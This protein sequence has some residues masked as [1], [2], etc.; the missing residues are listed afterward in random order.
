MSN[1]AEGITIRQSR[2]L[3]IRRENFLLGTINDQPA[4]FDFKRSKPKMKRDLLPL[5]FVIKLLQPVEFPH[6]LGILGRLYGR[7]LAAQG[8]CWVRTAAGIPWKLDLQNSC[9]RWIVYGKYEGPGFINWA[10]SFLPPN[11]IVVDSG[12]NIGQMLLYLGQ[13]IPAGKVLAFEPGKEQ[14]DWLAECLGQNPELPVE[15]IRMGL[16]D[17]KAELFLQDSGAAMMHGGQSMVS[18]DEGLPITVNRLEDE[19]K[20]RS[21]KHVD[22]WKLDVEGHEIKALEGARELLQNRKIRAL[23]V[24]LHAEN[25]AMICDFL[26]KLDYEPFLITNRGS[27]QQL[28]KLPEHTN[29]LFLPKQG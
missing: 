2:R 26:S 20:N 5:P 13:F 11:G 25:G 14:A 18:E 16:S 12:A 22:L 23:Y 15:L 3:T 21:L 17:K 28:K 24:E 7:K 6:K 10:K 4:K 29:G 9:H 1:A 27:L 8:V 19:L